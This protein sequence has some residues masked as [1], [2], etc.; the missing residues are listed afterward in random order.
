[1]PTQTPL[2]F[3]QIS[4]I[5]ESEDGKKLA[6]YKEILLLY[7]LNGLMLILAVPLMLEILELDVVITWIHQKLRL[8]KKLVCGTIF[9]LLSP[10]LLQVQSHRLVSPTFH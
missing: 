3:Q 5:R 7:V 8:N 9:G 1:M 6:S 2:P 10:E 4:I